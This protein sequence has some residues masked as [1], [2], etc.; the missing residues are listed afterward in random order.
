MKTMRLVKRH[1]IFQ[2]RDNMHL[3]EGRSDT[4][5]SG[6]QFSGGGS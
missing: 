6:L 3:N 2:V 5:R 1:A 4:L